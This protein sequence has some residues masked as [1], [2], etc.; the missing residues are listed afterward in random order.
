[1]TDETTQPVTPVLPPDPEPVKTEAAPSTKAVGLV[2]Q[3]IH[4]DGRNRRNADDGLEGGFVKII[5]GEHEG[6]VGAYV[7]TLEH[8]ADGWPEKILVRSRDEHNEPL[9]V[10]YSDV[11]ATD[12]KGGR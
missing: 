5:N 7:Q 11:A 2:A 1:M 3:P 12:Y 9:V 4:V 10:A 6:R 8:A